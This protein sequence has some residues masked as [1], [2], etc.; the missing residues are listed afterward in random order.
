[1]CQSLHKLFEQFAIQECKGFD[2]KVGRGYN[3]HAPH[4]TVNV[5]WM[6]KNDGWNVD[7]IG[8]RTHG[9]VWCTSVKFLNVGERE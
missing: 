3:T 4:S 7:A 5:S 9:G 2:N 8:V 1:M 6:G